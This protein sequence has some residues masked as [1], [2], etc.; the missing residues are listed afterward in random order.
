MDAQKL[1]DNFSTHLKNVI[2]RAIS[3]ATYLNYTNVEPI[4]LL[5]ALCEEQGSIGAE[6][7]KK[8][9]LTTDQIY[10]NILKQKEL[11]EKPATLKKGINYDGINLPELSAYSRKVLEKALTRAHDQGHTYIGTE[12]LLYGL[13][14]SPDHQLVDLINKLKID[15]KAIEEQIESSL[16]NTSKFSDI[17]DATD[18][19][20]EFGGQ[21]PGPG[22]MPPLSQA[23]PFPSLGKQNSKN[24]SAVAMFTTDLTSK[25]AQKNIDPVIG[26]KDEIERIINILS[27]RN[28]NNPILAGE[29]G[30]GKTAIVEGLARKIVEGDVP[31]ILKRKK[32]LA[33][34]LTLLVAGTIYRG[35]FEARLKQIVDECA[36]NPNY[37]LFIDELHNI[38]GTGSNQGTMDAANILKPALARGQLR[39]IGATTLDE[40]K[41]YITTDPA[42]ERRFQEIYIE[43]PSTEDTLKILKGTKKYYEQFHNVSITNKA[44]EAAMEYSG[45]YIHDNFQPDKSIDLIDEACGAVKTKQKLSSVQNKY[46]KLLDELEICEQEKEIAISEERLKDALNWKNKSKGLQNKITLLKNEIEKNKQTPKTQVTHKDI[47]NIVSKKLHIDKRVILQ[48]EWENLGTLESRI[49]KYIVGQDNTIKKV[50][51]S[52]RRSYLRDDNTHKPLASFLFV[53]SSG[54]GKTELAKVLARELYHD[55]KALIKLDMSEFAE[56]HSVSKLL[57]SPA[58][59]IG[60]RDRNPII[61]KI[62]KKPYSVVLFDEIDKAHSDVTKLLLQILD[63]GILS[64]SNSKKVHFRQ[65]IIIM[66]SNLGAELFKSSGIGFGGDKKNQKQ[67]SEFEKNIINKLKEELGAALLS[68]TGTTCIL[69]VL[70]EKDTQKIIAQHI[71]KIANHLNKK[72]K[73]SVSGDNKALRQIAKETASIEF[74]A[75]NVEKK[76]EELIHELV[77]NIMKEKTKKQQYTLTREKNHYTLK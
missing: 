52:L 59:Y 42:L 48:S 24:P 40:Y 72:Y 39:C 21:I 73:L 27:R 25:Q 75:R 44:L 37:I 64:D 12:H 20:E 26:R 70:T 62:K 19:L 31:D 15:K 9:E 14:K 3:L 34:D 49:K 60:Y 1:I 7:L 6:I 54:V 76:V 38:I 46:Y 68:R 4:H 69:N 56:S 5:I 51:E 77:V 35:E 74:G 13:V 17:G 2:A 36:Q 33:L 28:K 22:M 55:E 23:I 18:I 43:E 63:E 47:A 50:V 10:T 29:P 16:H 61:D 30:V 8:S 65:S 11:R 71:E 32:I 41:K 58:G 45:R 57:G 66:T 53:G 67:D